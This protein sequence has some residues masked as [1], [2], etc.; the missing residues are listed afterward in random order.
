MAEKIGL[1]F[2]CFIFLTFLNRNLILNIANAEN[3]NDDGNGERNRRI[4]TT[5]PMKCTREAAMWRETKYNSLKDWAERVLYESGFR[6]KKQNIKKKLR[7]REQHNN[8]DI[9]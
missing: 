3:D 9:A 6:C 2:V 7:D 1:F 8:S 5:I 4:A